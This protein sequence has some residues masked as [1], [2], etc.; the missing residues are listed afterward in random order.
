MNLVSIACRAAEEN[1]A[2]RIKRLTVDVGEMT[3][4][5][6]KYLF[7]YFPEASRKTACEGAELVVNEIKVIVTCAC[8]GKDYHP[9][10]ANDRSCPYCRGTAGKIKSGRE[11]MVSEIIADEDQGGSNDSK[12]TL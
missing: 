6:P 2:S 8:C 12:G 9:E 10:P 4:I 5:L 11:L 7:H 1:G 3:G